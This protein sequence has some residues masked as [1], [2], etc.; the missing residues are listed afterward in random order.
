MCTSQRAL[1]VLE[2]P[3]IKE[4][5]KS[6]VTSSLGR[7]ALDDLQPGQ[8]YMEVRSRIAVGQE[9]L[10]LCRDFSQP[11][12]GGLEDPLPLL[13]KTGTQGQIL[14]PA[15]LFRLSTFLASIKNLK[16]Y[17][18]AMEGDFPR[19][20]EIG[21]DLQPCADLKSRIDMCIEESG[22]ISD[23][24]SAVLR[25]V[26]RDLRTLRTR[27]R[28]QMERYL[29][30]PQYKDVI[31][32][33][34]VT[35]RRD[36]YVIPLRS[37]FKGKID[38]I[39]L[40]HSAS[41]GTFYVEPREV[42]DVNNRL[43]TLHAQ[44]R[45]EEY[46]II[47]ELSQLV[48]SRMRALQ[49]NVALVERI[50][51]YIG[52]ANY[53][54]KHDGTYLETRQSRGCCLPG[55]RHP[56]LEN[57]VAVDTRLGGDFPPM[58]L[59]TG[60]NTGGKTLA[61]K[62]AGLAVLSHNSGIPVLCRENES[63]M[64]YFAAIYADIGDEQSIEQSLSTFSSHIV[65][66]AHAAKSVDERSLVLLDELGS[67]TD[68]EEGG[69]LAVG[70]LQYFAQ[71]KCC[72]MATTHHN[73]VKHFAHR[74]HQV[75]NACMEF[76]SQ[77]LQPTYRILYGQQGQSSA[78]DIAARYG[79]PLEIV[80]AARNF[81]ESST[82]EAA[83]TI[84]ALERKLERYVRDDEAFQS[85][86]RRL[87]Q[88]LQA[89]QQQKQ[90]LQQQSSRNLEQ[91]SLQARDIVRQARQEAKR[92]LQN[93]KSSSDQEAR[94]QQARFESMAQQVF[95]DAQQMERSHLQKLSNIAAGD[96]VYV[97]KLQR[98]GTV[99][100]VRGKKA[101]VEVG[102]LRTQVG[103]DELFAPRGQAGSATV[104]TSSGHAAE[105]A[106][107]AYVGPHHAVS[108]ELM[109][110]GKRVEE[111]LGELEDYLSRAISADLDSVRIIHGMGTG[112]LKRAVRHYLDQVPQV[113]NYRDGEAFE[114][115]LGATVVEL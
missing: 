93:L 6:F 89:L 11:P 41:G 52:F 24:A 47:S 85:R 65:N 107:P 27:V 28:K 49:A 108:P 39:V 46:R 103:V 26:R 95:A 33:N 62:S 92:Y 73:A 71:R 25:K 96:Q 48:Q 63:F 104:H 50:D 53:A 20:R 1:A 114:G 88:E 7:R 15:E 8:S 55:L 97:A 87:E 80:D 18:A 112:R 34:I 90:Q 16:D 98:D 13:E 44:E 3:K 9:F 113:K 106:A 83:R 72:L 42:V 102:G 109:L 36:R 29:G 69:A 110:V 57:P 51:M 10:L 91:A 61:L 23:G 22:H 115:G 21:G 38:G 40:D 74:N 59:I 66:I 5:L 60:P 84:A 76:D 68:P 58:L 77:T 105:S 4:F 2:Y 12:M 100:T 17:F 37:N 94:R 54:L 81:R 111:S 56:L 31:I 70:I 101:E 99:I 19:S 30:D 86:S 78:L 14:E 79:L 82:G 64:G 75:E 67:G 32:D 43:A 35:L 45:E